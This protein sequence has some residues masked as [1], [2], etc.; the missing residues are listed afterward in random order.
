[1]K[2]TFKKITA[3]V[4]SALF[5]AVVI[6]LSIATIISKKSDF[7][8]LENRYLAEKPKISASAWFSG[9]YFS[10]WSEYSREHF[11][12]RPRWIS[13]RTSLER[14]AGHEEVNGIYISGGRLYEA[15]APV[16]YETVDR[17]VAAI[18]KFGE[19]LEGRLSVM[20]APTSSQIYA[21]L[22]PNYSPLQEQR[23]MINYVYSALEGSAQTIDV[24]DPLYRA[25]D[26]YI[27]YRTD[28]HWT[29]YGAYI[30]YSTCIRRFGYSPVTLDKIDVEHASRSFLGSYY[31]SVIVDD[32]EPD[33]IDFYTSGGAEIS[34]VKITRA[35]GTTEER[36]SVFFREYLDKKDKYLCYLGENV[37]MIEITSEAGGGSI[38]VIKDSYANCF[39][40]FLTKHFSRVVLVDLRY[41]M[42]LSD[43]VDVSDFDRALILYNASTFAEDG[44]IPKLAAYGSE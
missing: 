43:Y 34:S 10:D 41:M 12:M 23:K 8:E 37:P 5:S 20:I 39:A 17:S 29:E 36:D 32:I 6:S 2:T 24:Y 27:Y 35:D 4:N 22:L 9:E 11:I 16:D 33:A 13:L 14:L 40:P 18:K 38:L 42:R 28:H 30:A 15:S 31:S 7:S 3:V 21:D 44:N 1:M 19:L 26:D 25:R